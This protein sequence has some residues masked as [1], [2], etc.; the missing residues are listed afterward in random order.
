MRGVA[1]EAYLHV[2]KSVR[3][4]ECFLLKT[5]MMPEGNKHTG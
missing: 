5:D 3:V 4:S 2:P 1:A